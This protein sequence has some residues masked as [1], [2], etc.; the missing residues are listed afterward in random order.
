MPLYTKINKHGLISIR[1]FCRKFFL[2]NHIYHKKYFVK[3]AA[4]NIRVDGFGAM[5]WISIRAAGA[6]TSLPH[7]LNA[8]LLV[9]TENFSSMN[10][11]VGVKLNVSLGNFW[12]KSSLDFSESLKVYLAKEFKHLHFCPMSNI[13]KF[14]S[15]LSVTK[16]WWLGE[17]L[18][19]CMIFLWDVMVLSAVLLSTSHTTNVESF[20]PEIKYLESDDHDKSKTLLVWP[21]FYV[22]WFN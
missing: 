22:E 9:K 3:S 8:S 11:R 12:P 19:P 15:M 5:H 17:K 6:K 21:L 10:L 13:L 7:G 1:N 20:P 18:V 2:L 16:C 14:R 4:L